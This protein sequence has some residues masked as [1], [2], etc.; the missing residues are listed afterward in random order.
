MSFDVNK[1]NENEMNSANNSLKSVAAATNSSSA[2]S[3][4]SLLKLPSSTK[5]SK[6]NTISY[7]KSFHFDK[8]FNQ[9]DACLNIPAHQRGLLF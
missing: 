8:H 6:S 7:F 3:S 1:I 5:L 9:A 4:L 2:G